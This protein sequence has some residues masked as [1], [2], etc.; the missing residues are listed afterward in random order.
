ML[1]HEF[2]GRGLVVRASA[3]RDRRGVERLSTWA[4]RHGRTVLVLRRRGRV[5][6]VLTRMHPRRGVVIVYRPGGSVEASTVTEA[7]RIGLARFAAAD[8]FR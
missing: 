1:R 3:D 4:L 2:F 8:R 5:T 6:S 7:V